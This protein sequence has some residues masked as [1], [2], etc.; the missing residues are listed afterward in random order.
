MSGG[1][2]MTDSKAGQIVWHDLFTS[3]RECSMAFYLQVANWTYEVE[4]AANF[5]WGGGEKNVFYNVL[6]VVLTAHSRPSRCRKYSLVD[7]H[8]GHSCKPHH[9]GDINDRNADFFT[10]GV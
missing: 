1:K 3:D 10:F 8:T 2:T 9:F 6:D 4:R 7:S 5:A